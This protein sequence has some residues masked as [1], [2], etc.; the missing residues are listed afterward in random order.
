MKYYNLARCHVILGGDWNP[1]RSHFLNSQYETGSFVL[2]L[3]FG[4]TPL[5]PKKASCAAGNPGRVSIRM[6]IQ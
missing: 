6:C 5:F 3:M 4:E 1:G 2:L